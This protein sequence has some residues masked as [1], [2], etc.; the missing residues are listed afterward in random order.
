MLR[1]GRHELAN[2]VAHQALAKPTIDDVRQLD[3]V[4]RL[5]DV[6]NATGHDF[7]NAATVEGGKVV[8][9]HV[10]DDP[11]VA[12]KLGKT[13]FVKSYGQRGKY[14]EL[15]PGFYV[16]AVPHLWIGRSRSK[17]A[18]LEK[19]TPQQTKAL[20]KLLRE[21]IERQYGMRR[22]TEREHETALRDL[23]YVEQ[24]TMGSSVL[25]SFANQPYVIPFWRPEWLDKI[26]VASAEPQAIKVQLFGT[27]AE[28]G[29]RPSAT[30]HRVLR[31]AGIA[32]IFTRAGFSLN[33][34]LAVFHGRSLKVL[35]VEDV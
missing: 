19:L 17:W 16:S 8:A 31:A 2:V 28:L 5:V 1:A 4:K 10:T 22:I 7:G 25:V 3:E 20:A 18:F 9:W 14:A 30:T 24:G 26:G 15:G 35:G 12:R 13:N 27:Y 21:E 29:G 6:S 11:S 34:E 33:A 32:G 23:G